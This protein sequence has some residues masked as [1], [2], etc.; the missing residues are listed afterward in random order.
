LYKVAFS[1]VDLFHTYKFQYS[2]KGTRLQRSLNLYL[3]LSLLCKFLNSIT[4]K[5]NPIIRSPK[6]IIAGKR[7]SS[8]VIF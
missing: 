7:R 5:T 4:V 8:V 6:T 1:L 2:L 3:F